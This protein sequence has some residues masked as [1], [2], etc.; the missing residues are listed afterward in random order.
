MAK[1]VLVN[2]SESVKESWFLGVV[3]S[4]QQGNKSL[5]VRP[6]QLHTPFQLKT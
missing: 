3:V 6:P 5:A 1:G 4:H 2:F